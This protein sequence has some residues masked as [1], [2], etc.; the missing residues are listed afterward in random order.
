MLAPA[1]AECERHREHVRVGPRRESRARARQ[2]VANFRVTG[3]RCPR[4]PQRS[5]HETVHI[6]YPNGRRRTRAPTI[7]YWTS[8]HTVAPA[9]A[10]TTTPSRAAHTTSIASD[11][12]DRPPRVGEGGAQCR[13]RIDLVARCPHLNRARTSFNP[14]R[15]TQVGLY[16][17]GD[18]GDDGRGDKATR[19]FESDDDQRVTAEDEQPQQVNEDADRPR[20]PR[21]VPIPQPLKDAVHAATLNVR[22]PKRPR[23]GPRVDVRRLSASDPMRRVDPRR[24]AIARHRGARRVAYR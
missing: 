18:S 20:I 23:V 1:V 14:G 10:P 2:R 21:S 19:S 11:S 9:I 17:H 22:H 24:G 7:A 3:H 6:H 4:R 8:R 5:F 15:T 16:Q 13:H 12:D